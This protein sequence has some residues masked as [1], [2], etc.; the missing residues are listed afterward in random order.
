MNQWR[1]ELLVNWIC[2]TKNDCYFL[3]GCALVQ[4][5][6]FYFEDKN[7]HFG[8]RGLASYNDIDWMPIHYAIYPHVFQRASVY[9]D[10]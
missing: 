2:I 9:I 1:S 7:K 10:L 3:K 5:K 8:Y 6:G 4:M